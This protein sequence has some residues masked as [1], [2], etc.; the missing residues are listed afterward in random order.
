[1]NLLDD[2]NSLFTGQNIST[3]SESNINLLGDNIK[4][5]NN[6]INIYQTGNNNS[7]LNDIFSNIQTKDS[8][9]GRL[10]FSS[11]KEIFKNNDIS[12]SHSI[13]LVKSLLDNSFSGSFYVANLTNNTLTNVNL[14]FMVLKF[15]T[16]KITY[17]SG[18]QIVPN[19]K[20]KKVNNSKFILGF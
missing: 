14:K 10:D 12:I 1:M 18:T 11:E 8:G 13:P 19:E 16:F 7:Q 2:L 3:K 5:D 4:I 15:V 17:T 6:L 20:I 9:I